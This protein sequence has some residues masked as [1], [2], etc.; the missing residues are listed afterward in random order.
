MRL[1]QELAELR[2]FANYADMV[3]AH[4]MI[5]NGR[6]ALDFVNGLIGR[7]KPQFERETRELL[8]FSAQCTGKPVER[9]EPWDETYYEHLLRMQK[10]DVDS[11]ALRPYFEAGATGAAYREAILS[12][13][14]SR[15]A[16]ELFR[17]FTGRSP[18]PDALLQEMKPAPQGKR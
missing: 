12:K 13:G 5:K 17:T 6:T 8:E 14:D 9:L 15:P 2:G 3:A 7:L 4:R 11:E 10:H 18:N 16:E 1:R